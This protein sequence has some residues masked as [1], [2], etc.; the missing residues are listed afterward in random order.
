MGNLKEKDLRGF[1]NGTLTPITLQGPATLYRFAGHPEGKGEWW[2]EESTFTMIY[3]EAR[4]NC[5]RSQS[6]TT[7]TEFRRLY[8]KYTAVSLNWNYLLKF[9]RMDV[10]AKCEVVGWVGKVKAQ[11][12]VYLDKQAELSRDIPG[13]L[14]GGLEQLFLESF[15]MSW[16]NSLSL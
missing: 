9:F 15:D 8:R 12:L 6:D 13:R 7:W 14:I 2:I 11:P 1:S 4:D 5:S 3:N 10:P 16:I